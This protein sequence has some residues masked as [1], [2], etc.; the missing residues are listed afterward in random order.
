MKRIAI[1]GISI[2]C[3]ERSPVRARYED[4]AIHRGAQLFAEGLSFVPGMVDRLKAEA[5]VQICPLMWAGA[6]PN[7]LVEAGAYA[8]L[9]GEMLARL[10]AEGPLDG[11]LISGHGALEVE[12]LVG[13]GESDYI[14]AVRQLIGPRVPLGIAFDLHGNLTAEIARA[15][16]VFD[17]LRTAPHIDHQQTGWRTA[18]QLL[19]VIKQGLNPLNALVPVPILISGEQAVT[20]QEPARSLYG[21]LQAYDA[22]PGD[23]IPGL[24]DV[25]L[26]VGFGFN[27]LPWCSMSVL[28]THASDAAEAAR[29]A[30]ELAGRVW[31]R[32]SEFV[33]SMETAPIKAGVQ[34]ALTAA[35]AQHPVYL[36]DS[37]DNTTA[38]ATGDLTLVLRELLEQ[39]APDAVVAGILAP[40]TVRTC[41]AAGLGSEI[42]LSIG[43]EQ[44]SLPCE[45]LTVRAVVAGLGS[46]EGEWAR[47]RIEGVTATFHT[48]RVSVTTRQEFH[49]LGIDPQAHAIY[50]VKLGYLFPELAQIARRHILLLSPGVARLDFQNRKWDRVP[51]PIY[52]LDPAMIWDAATAVIPSG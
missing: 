12:G 52:P 45:P 3:L 6:L 50:V 10:E 2:E 37:G 5:G 42:E 13:H 30:R 25:L 28:A 27:D 19:T 20:S 38:G 18:D 44:L 9:K 17:A 14:S 11:V 1:T 15:G 8:R 34:R 24:L 26:M 39:R 36:T 35:P 48:R 23:A 21:G 22:I 47:L 33:L 49:R 43:A 29:V 4:F 32:R 16:T 40:Q 7:G 41:Q 51:R 31:A 46:G